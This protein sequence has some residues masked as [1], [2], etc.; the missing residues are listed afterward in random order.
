MVLAQVPSVALHST[1][2]VLIWMTPAKPIRIVAF[3]QEQYY[4][5]LDAAFLLP[6]PFAAGV[7]TPTV[8]PELR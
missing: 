7:I 8:R 1:C 2:E 5:K 3:S 6:A 4:Q